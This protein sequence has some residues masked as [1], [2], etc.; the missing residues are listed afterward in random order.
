MRHTATQYNTLKHTATHKWHRRHRAV[1]DRKA[2]AS[3]STLQNTTTHKCQKRQGL[4]KH[5]GS[6][7]NKFQHPNGKEDTEQLSTICCF[8][9]RRAA[10]GNQQLYLH[11]Q[12]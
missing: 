1:T 6:Q 4:M 10:L 7:C 3:A 8:R 5:T 11:T 2:V 12:L 9:K